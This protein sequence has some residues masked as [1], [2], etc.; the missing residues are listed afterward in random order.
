MVYFNSLPHDELRLGDGDI[1]IFVFIFFSKRMRS[2]IE[3]GKPVVNYRAVQSV[4]QTNKLPNLSSRPL[5]ILYFCLRRRVF[6]RQQ[7][8]LPFKRVVHHH[9]GFISLRVQLRIQWERF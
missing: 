8:P 9:S 3:F 7:Q 2:H 4:N 5:I 6:F 1:Y